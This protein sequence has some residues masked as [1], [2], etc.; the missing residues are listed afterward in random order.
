MIPADATA[1]VNIVNHEPGSSCKCRFGSKHARAGV[2]GPAGTP[3]NPV[4]RRTASLLQ[5]LPNLSQPLFE[6]LLHDQSR[7]LI[8][9]VGIGLADI[10]VR[11]DLI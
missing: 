11:V 5:H 10:E 8:Q 6:L 7:R 3:P 2:S 4:P 1:I 9:A